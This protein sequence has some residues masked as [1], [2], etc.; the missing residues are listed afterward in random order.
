MADLL[1]QLFICYICVK[2]GAND[3]LNRFDCCLVEDGNGGRQIKFILKKNVPEAIGVPYAANNFSEQEDDCETNES[4]DITFTR[5]EPLWRDRRRDM[6][7]TNARECNEIVRQFM[8]IDFD[9]S[10]ISTE[11]FD[12]REAANETSI[13][14]DPTDLDWSLGSEEQHSRESPL[15]L[16]S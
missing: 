6:S 2:L 5:N 11:T 14:M 12:E 13:N 9:E 8:E 10:M 4:V 15:N 16:F 3:S 7:L 1:I